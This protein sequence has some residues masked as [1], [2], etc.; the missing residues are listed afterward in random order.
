MAS[1]V[2]IATGAAVRGRISMASHYAK[3]LSTYEKRNFSN[4]ERHCGGG[5]KKW[6][7]QS[8]RQQRLIFLKPRSP[9]LYFIGVTTGK[10]SIMNVFPRW[11]EFLKLGDVRIQGID[12][13]VNERP[14]VY[15]R[16][17]DFIK[18]DPLSRGALVTT[19]KI[20]LLN[21]CRD[22][23]DELDSYTQFLGEVS[24]ISK[25][26]GKLSGHAK[27]PIS[28]GLALKAFVPPDHFQRTDAHLLILGAG[29]SSIAFSSYLMDPKRDQTN[30][31]PGRIAITD[32]SPQRLQEIRLGS[33]RVG[34]GRL[35]VVHI[36]ASSGRTRPIR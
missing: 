23:F 10:S 18:D 29:G 11:A 7:T 33:S 4:A 24:A 1:R 14:E 3:R 30:D 20:D 26:D 32:T 28:S 22:C 31:R 35:R 15:R 9:T 17:L 8:P 19:H 12:V 27:D 13:K 34:L 21:A 6:L 36:I 16:I 5:V 2:W 25:R